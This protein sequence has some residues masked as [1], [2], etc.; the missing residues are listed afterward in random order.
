MKDYLVPM[1]E[2]EKVSVDGWKYDHIKLI[3]E[4]SEM[5]KKNK[6]ISMEIIE[7]KQRAVYDSV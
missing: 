4:H 7:W 5:K 6:E 2:L 1:I 3:E